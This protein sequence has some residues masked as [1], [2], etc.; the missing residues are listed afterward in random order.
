MERIPNPKFIGSP[1]AN[2]ERTSRRKRYAPNKNESRWNC[3]KNGSK[4]SGNELKTTAE[5]HKKRPK[6]NAN[7]TGIFRK[8]ATCPKKM[9]RKPAIATINKNQ[10]ETNLESQQ[11]GKIG[12]TSSDAD[13]TIAVLAVKSKRYL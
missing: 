2:G 13:R 11:R 9:R 6:E 7:C 12:T 3:R 10:K 8:I 4:L 5:K 1:S